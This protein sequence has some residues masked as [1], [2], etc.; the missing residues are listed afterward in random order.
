VKALLQHDER[1]IDIG[2]LW[3]LTGFN[4]RPHRVQKLSSSATTYTL[5]HKLALLLTSVTS[6]SNAPLRAI[7]YIGS[8]ISCGSLMFLL[9]IVGQWLTTK[10]PVSGWT[11]LIISIWLLGGIIIAFLGVIGLYISQMF[12]EVKRRPFTIVRRIYGRE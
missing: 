8:A 3:A 5:R 4:Q 12:L 1:E 6:F 9:F 7:F 11:S 2:G 10:N